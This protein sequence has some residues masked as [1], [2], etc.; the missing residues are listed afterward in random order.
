VEGDERPIAVV[1][2]DRLVVVTDGGRVHLEVDE[3]QKSTYDCPR[4][5]GP[6]SRPS[7]P[8]SLAWLAGDGSIVLI[9]MPSSHPRSRT[10]AA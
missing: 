8:F 10:S 3:K 5:I 2:R 6:R 9:V 1:E 7:F 4:E